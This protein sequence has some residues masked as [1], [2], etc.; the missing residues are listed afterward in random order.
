MLH[1]FHSILLPCVWSDKIL[2]L[3]HS[4]HIPPNMIIHN[5]SCSY[6]I[7]YVKS[8]DS[9]VVLYVLT[10]QNTII[11]SVKQYFQNVVGMQAY[12]I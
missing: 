9:A 8:K 5:M 12:S 6:S 10:L 3:C 7:S 11:I 2:I 4:F 1:T